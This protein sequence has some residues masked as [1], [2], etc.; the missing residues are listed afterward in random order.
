VRIAS[1]LAFVYT[2]PVD[3]SIKRCETLPDALTSI[4]LRAEHSL[5]DDA[6]RASNSRCQPDNIRAG[7]KRHDAATPAERECR[8]REVSYQEAAPRMHGSIRSLRFH[9]TSAPPRERSSLS[10]DDMHEAHA[11]RHHAMVDP[12]QCRATSSSSSS[13]S[14]NKRS[15]VAF[16]GS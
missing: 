16:G 2:H 6:R 8:S 7:C 9:I 15:S 5:S 11:T 3:A 14:M 13:S 12:A 10:V 1:S 4:P